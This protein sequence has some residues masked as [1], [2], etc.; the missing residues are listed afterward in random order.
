MLVNVD[1]PVVAGRLDAAQVVLVLDALRV[2]R[3]AALAVA[4]PEVDGGARERRARVARR[5]G[6]ASRIVSGTPSAVPDDAPKRRGDVAAHDAAL[7]EHVGPVRAVA[8]ERP[9]GLLGDHRGA[10]LGA[11]GRRS[12]RG[13]RH[14]VADEMAPGAQAARKAPTP[15]SPISCS[16]RRRSTSVATSAWRPWSY[17]S[18]GSGG[19]A[20]PLGRLVVMAGL[21]RVRLTIMRLAGRHENPLTGRRPLQG[22]VSIDASFRARAAGKIARSTIRPGTPRGRPCAHKPVR[23]IRGPPPAA[24]GPAGNR[25]R[26]RVGA[27]AAR[28]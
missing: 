1:H 24:H 10:G 5:P 6:S 17:R 22:D 16:T 11:G 3:V 13:G 4:V 23:D 18:N 12:G 14:E 15:A 26:R 7:G 9:G 21:Q 19:A 8:R 25:R 20:T 27:G 2:Q 28:W